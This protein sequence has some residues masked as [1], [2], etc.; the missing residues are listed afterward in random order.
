M[1]RVGQITIC[2]SASSFLDQVKKVSNGAQENGR[3][4][5]KSGR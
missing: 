2:K 1:V 4:S 5:W 3:L